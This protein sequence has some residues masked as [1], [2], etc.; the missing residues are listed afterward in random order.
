MSESKE[1]LLE[2]MKANGKLFEFNFYLSEIFIS[3]C[4]LSWR[5]FMSSKKSST[6]MLQFSPH[7]K[8][9]K[10]S[11]FIKS[12][13]IRFYW[14]TIFLNLFSEIQLILIISKNST[15]LFW[16]PVLVRIITQCSSGLLQRNVACVV[17][18][19]NAK[20]FIIKGHL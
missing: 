1:T 13:R 16:L 3:E 10:N 18:C 5:V 19:W 20:S 9:H 6:E 15:K 2:K 7:C 14:S 4:T 12:F 8:L 17:K 11:N